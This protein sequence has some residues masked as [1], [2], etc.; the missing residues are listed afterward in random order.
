MG[1]SDLKKVSIKERAII[2]GGIVGVNAYHADRISLKHSFFQ[3]GYQIHETDHF[4]FLTR[5]AAPSTVIVHW[6]APEAIDA[7]LGSYLM[8]ELKPPGLLTQP[9]NFSDAFGAIVCSLSPYDVQK[10][11]YIFASNTLHRYHHL[12]TNT[13][14]FPLFS[15][16]IEAFA[17]LYH[18]VNKLL[19][20]Q[21]LLDAGCSYGFFP[22][23][24]AE[25]FPSLTKVFGVDIRADHFDVIRRLAEEQQLLNVQF[26]HADLLADD[27]SELGQ[28]D[29]VTAL[30]VLEHFSEKD[31]YRVLM[32]LLKVT[33]R[34]LIIAVPFEV[35]EVETIYGHEQL[36]SRT[37]LETVGNWCLQQ[38]GDGRMNC[39][40]I[41]SGLLLVERA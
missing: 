23:L 3:E 39:E 38:W 17:S 11:W 4:F 9:Q 14:S 2:M 32:N 19:V 22:I 12:L 13:P 15:P 28:F 8:Q 20:G 10:A 34:R 21:T 1:D 24:V 40:D 7:N 31:M 5:V 36:F 37:L 18:R 35:G 27:F 41:A 30:H 29:T 6:F 25:R 33:A 16:P 26:T